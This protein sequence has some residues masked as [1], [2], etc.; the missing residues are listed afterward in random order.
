MGD[1]SDECDDGL[2][3]DVMKVLSA[4]DSFFLTDYSA[5]FCYGPALLCSLQLAVLL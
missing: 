4:L 2:S 1:D 3:V 5:L